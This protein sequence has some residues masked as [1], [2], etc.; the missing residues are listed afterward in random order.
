MIHDFG[1][2]GHGAD[3]DA[4]VRGADCFEFL[5]AAQIHDDFGLL[6]AVLEPIEAVEPAGQHPGVLSI[7]FEKLLRVG[8]RCG[9]KQL[10]G[11]HNVSN[12]SHCD[13]LIEFSG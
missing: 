1:E 5:D 11:R 13:F 12:Y 4:V 2:S 8:G 9:L 6:D 3:L 7:L 10:E